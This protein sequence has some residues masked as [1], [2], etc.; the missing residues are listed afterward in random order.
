[1]KTSINYIAIVLMAVLGAACTTGGFN[2][3]PQLEELENALDKA[4]NVEAIKVNGTVIEKNTQ[5]L[6]EVDAS[7]GDVLKLEAD[8]TSGKDAQLVE[9]EFY[10]Q[11]Y[12][13]VNGQEAP[14]PVDTLTDGFYNLS[15]LESTFSYDYTV[16]AVDDDDFDFEV[17]TIITIQYRL[18]N[19]LD[20]YGY[21]A[22][23]IHIVDKEE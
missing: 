18:K 22:L 21:R 20:N 8:F 9:L 6:R 1:M 15:G 11:Y 23:V 14:H 13:R 19:S 16:P 12:G 5:S 4:P 17:G 7:I 10:R 3:N 2:N